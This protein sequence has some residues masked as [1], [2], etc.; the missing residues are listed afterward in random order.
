MA[1]ADTPYEFQYSTA[2]NRTAMGRLDHPHPE[3]PAN[4][5]G[6]IGTLQQLPCRSGSLRSLV[7][8]VRSR[9]GPGK[10]SP[11]LAASEGAI[12]SPFGAAGHGAG[13][14]HNSNLVDIR[15]GA[16]QHHRPV[17]TALKSCAVSKRTAAFDR[18]T[19]FPSG[20][21]GTYVSSL[22]SLGIFGSW[23]LAIR[24]VRRD[25]HGPIH[26]LRRGQWRGW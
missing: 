16:V 8:E 3:V 18:G 15:T 19:E 17:D 21:V 5:G 7:S 4:K 11:K 10:C 6:P 24:M 25:T 2:T 22:C 23:A 12:L 13:R 1:R 20:V 26:D 9:R 14:C